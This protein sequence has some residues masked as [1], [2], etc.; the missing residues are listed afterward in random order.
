MGSHVLPWMIIRILGL[1]CNIIARLAEVEDIAAISQ[2]QDECSIV[3]LSNTKRVR[4]P[5]SNVTSK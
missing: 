2:L 1:L 3:K 4:I 5:T